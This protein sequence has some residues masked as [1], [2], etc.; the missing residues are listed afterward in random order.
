MGYQDRSRPAPPEDGHILR[1]PMVDRGI[2]APSAVAPAGESSLSETA[3]RVIIEE[4][5][6]EYR[7]T[8]KRLAKL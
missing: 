4:L 6:E 3:R 5:L 8:W 1:E 7:E 2:R